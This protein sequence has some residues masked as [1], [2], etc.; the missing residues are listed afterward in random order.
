MTGWHAWQQAIIHHQRAVL[1]AATVLG[2]GASYFAVS[3]A[4]SPQSASSPSPHSSA[5]NE[6]LPAQSARSDRPTIPSSTPSPTDPSTD[7]STTATV[8]GHT[9]T[10]PANGSVHQEIATPGG[11]I[12]VDISNN[13]ADISTLQSSSTSLNSQDSGSVSLQVQSQS[14]ISSGSSA[15]GGQEL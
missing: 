13:S 4:A 2:V 12:T 8:N 5:I 7:S 6:I 1:G 3:L 15:G 11:N 14:S 10:A 9:V